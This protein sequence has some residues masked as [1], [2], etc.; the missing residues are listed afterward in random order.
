M[1]HQHFSCIT[2]ALVQ[3][4]EQ[5]AMLVIKDLALTSIV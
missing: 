2:V 5:D 4:V 1:V 3:Y